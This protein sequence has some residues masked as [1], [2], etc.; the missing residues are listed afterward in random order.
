MRPM[1]LLPVALLALACAKEPAPADSAAAAAPQQVT[2]TATDYGFQLPASPIAAGV[3]TMTLVNTGKELHQVTLI[4]LTDGK[5]VADLMT[6][7]QAPGAPPAW[8]VASGGPNAAAPGGQATA[9]LNLEPG[10]YAIICFIPS[11]DG[12][13]HVAKGMVIG[14]DVQPAG[15]PSAALPS[16]DVQLTMNDYSFSLSGLPAAGPHTVSVSNQ[17]K[18]IHEVVVMRL[19]PGATPETVAAWFEG[20]Q[21][22]PPPGE[23]FAGVSGIAPGQLQ[24][25]TADFTPG[26][27]G[28]ICFAPAPDG[29]PHFMHGMTMTFTVS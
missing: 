17:G 28:L 26:S 19:A 4:R 10:P 29:K 2:I 27:Y 3:T 5:T 16:G 6:A 13:P 23:P 20:G 18:E 24:D 1:H 11:P 12:V 7:L 8:A 14:M 21:K 22:G 15:A 9:T 25:F